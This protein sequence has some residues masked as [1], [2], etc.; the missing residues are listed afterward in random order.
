MRPL[1]GASPSDLRGGT[2][3][4]VIPKKSQK[5]SEICKMGP[6]SAAGR[7]EQSPR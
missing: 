6:R 4:F 2:R 7:S 1:S 5:L 3:R